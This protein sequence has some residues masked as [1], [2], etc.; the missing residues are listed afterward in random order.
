MGLRR[1]G[2]DHG[3][4]AR[5]A[6]PLRL[7]T[8]S[9]FNTRQGVARMRDELGGDPEVEQLIASIES[10]RRGV[11]KAVPR[12]KGRGLADAAGGDEDE[13][14][15]G[16]AVEEGEA[17]AAAAGAGAGRGAGAGGARGGA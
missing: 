1:K 15:E 6:R 2:C 13:P 5:H 11:I 4:E 3:H 16:E 9:G 10:S 12:G 14:E 7:Q 8:R 17:A